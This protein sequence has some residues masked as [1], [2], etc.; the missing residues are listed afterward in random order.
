MTQHDCDQKPVTG[1][2]LRWLIAAIG[3]IAIAYP[4]EVLARASVSIIRKTVGLSEARGEVAVQVAGAIGAI[5]GAFIG[6][7]GASST[8]NQMQSSDSTHSS[9]SVVCA[10]EDTLLNKNRDTW[11]SL[12]GNTPLK[13]AR[14][15]AADRR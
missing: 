3:S 6:W 5:L 10:D 7:R 1:Y 14:H 13:E 15:P 8:A 9:N 11:V 2:R 4:A 12:V